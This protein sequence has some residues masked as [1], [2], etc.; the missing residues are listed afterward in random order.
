MLKRTGKMFCIGKGV[1]PPP[2]NLKH[3]KYIVSF[4][5]K[6]SINLENF[7][8]NFFSTKLLKKVFAKRYNRN[9]PSVFPNININVPNHLPNIKPII[10]VG[11]NIGHNNKFKKMVIIK[12]IIVRKKILLSLYFSIASLFSFINSTNKKI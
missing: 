8:L 9:P 11:N 6:K 1:P 5:L 12:K 2:I 3:I 4:L 10:K 7:V